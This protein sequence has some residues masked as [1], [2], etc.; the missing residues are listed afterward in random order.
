MLLFIFCVFYRARFRR[1]APVAAAL[2]LLSQTIAAAFVVSASLLFALLM[3]ALLFP[4]PEVKGRRAV[5]AAALGLVALGMVVTGLRLIPEGGTLVTEAPTRGWTGLLAAIPP[6]FLSHG[7]FASRPL[8]IA[9]FPVPLLA[10]WGYVLLLRK[11]TLVI[12]LMGILVGLQ[13]QNDFI[14][15]ASHWHMGFVYLA[16]VAVLWMDA[17]TEDQWRWPPGELGNVVVFARWS[18]AWVVPIFLASQA[19]ISVGPAL[20]DWRRPYSSSRAFGEWIRTRPELHRA[21]LVGEPDYFM[22]SVAYYAP[23]PLYLPR[24]RR[25]GRVVALTARNRQSLTLEELLETARKLRADHDAPVLIALG[26][27]LRQGFDARLFFSYGKEYAASSAM[28]DRFVRETVEVA[29]F[30][31]AISDENYDVY[32]LKGLPQ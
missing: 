22:E 16:F 4:P 12:A 30:R 3:E 25:F 19:A 28:V 5:S 10:A 11:P 14:S 32:L 29:S 13:L 2:F 7:A 6:A 8:G 20:A 1:I 23:N 9:S 15:P 18:R 31:E 24:E 26:H 17:G 27:P 21:I